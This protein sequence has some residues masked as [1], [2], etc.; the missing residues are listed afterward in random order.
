MLHFISHRRKRKKISKSYTPH[1]Y[2]ERYCKHSDLKIGRNASRQYDY[3]WSKSQ[4]LQHQPDVENKAASLRSHNK[5]TLG[6][7]D[8]SVAL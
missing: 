6:Q 7:F 2:L 1:P 4:L 3:L 8:S 5:K